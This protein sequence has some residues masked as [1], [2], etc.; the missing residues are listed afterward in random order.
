MI[1]LYFQSGAEA[2]ICI[3]SLLIS[4]WLQQQSFWINPAFVVAPSLHQQTK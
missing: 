3:I 1:G 4:F 2:A